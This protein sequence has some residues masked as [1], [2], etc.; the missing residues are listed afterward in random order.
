LRATLPHCE[1]I[2]FAGADHSSPWNEDLKGKTKLVASI[3]V[4]FFATIQAYKTP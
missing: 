1:C 3:L 2:E 4:E